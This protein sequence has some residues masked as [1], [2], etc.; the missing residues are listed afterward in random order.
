MKIIKLETFT[1]K[2]VGFVKVTT[3]TNDFGWGQ[4]STYNADISALIFHRQVAPWSLGLELIEEKPNFSDHLQKILEKEHKFPGSYLLR[5]LSGLDTALWDLYGRFHETPVASL[6][7]GSPQKIR[8]YGSSMRRDITPK[9]EAKRLCKLRDNNGFTAFKFR[10][11]SECGRDLDEWEG[12]SEEIVKL[13][14][15]ELGNDVEKL[16][17][18]NSCFSPKKAIELGKYLED[19]GI[20]HFEEPCPY[21]E[22]NQTK[23]VKEALLL[24]VAGGEQDCD[25]STWK[26]TIEKQIVNIVQ[27]DIMYMGGLSRTLDV[28]RMAYNESLPCTPHAANLSL[29]TVCTM[30]LLTAIPNAGKYL[31]LSIEDETYYPWQKNLFLGSPFEVKDGMVEVKDTPGWGVDIDPKWFDNCDYNIT[32]LN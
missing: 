25:M 27:P 19:Q 17:D 28:A 29:V 18:G 26:S 22:H 32:E 10:V 14:S 21:W 6:I 20:S 23:E 13:V 31:E 9:D 16:V 30:H 24:D 4:M 1:N 2:Y 8:A 5:A 3:N 15:S 7:G 11:G 12:R